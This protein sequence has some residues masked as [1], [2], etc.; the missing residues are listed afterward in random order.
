MLRRTDVE[1][2]LVTEEIFV[3]HLLKKVGGDARVAPA[4]W[5]AR[6]HRVSGCEHVLW[7]VGIRH[8]AHPPGIHKPHLPKVALITCW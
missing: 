4:V 7:Y 3:D 2:H 6:T 1:A 5:Q 8:L